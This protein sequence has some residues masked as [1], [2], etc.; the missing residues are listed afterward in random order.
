MQ[1]ID[2]K[3]LNPAKTGKKFGSVVDTSGARYVVP[4]RLIAQL[5]AG[6]CFECEIAEKL[7]GGD[8]VKVVEHITPKL[9]PNGANGISTGRLPPVSASKD[10]T[11]FV[12]ALVK[13]F[14][15]AGRLADASPDALVKVIEDMRAVYRRTL[16]RG[17]S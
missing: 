7:W 6:E 1:T 3:Y 5:K 17:V 10:E 14:I 13:S 8:L 16:G 9:P 2:V 4:E 15:E 11:V 12:L